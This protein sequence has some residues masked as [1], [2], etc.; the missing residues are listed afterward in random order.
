MRGSIVKDDLG[1]FVIV[2]EES[3]D[4]AKSIAEIAKAR[5]SCGI[6]GDKEMRHLA[7]FPGIAIQMYC[8][9]AG[10]EWSEWFANPEHARRMM[11]D[12]ALAHFRVHRGF[13]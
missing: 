13:V 8:D 7:E 1:R 11:N 10:I 6:T 3:L 4:Y 9:A 12:P 5:Q 2:H